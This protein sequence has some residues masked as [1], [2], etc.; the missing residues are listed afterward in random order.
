MVAP[1]MLQNPSVKHWL[2]GVEPAWT[3]LDQ[4]SWAAL[5]EPNL[6]PVNGKREIQRDGRDGDGRLQ[7]RAPMLEAIAG[8]RR[9]ALINAGIGAAAAALLVLMGMIGLRR[10]PNVKPFS[11]AD[12]LPKA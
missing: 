11:S 12:N 10:I 6:W 2:G 5:R 7:Q 8:A 9:D 3:L 1:G 4:A